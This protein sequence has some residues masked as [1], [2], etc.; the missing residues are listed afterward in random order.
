[1]VAVMSFVICCGVNRGVQMV[2]RYPARGVGYDLYASKAELSDDMGTTLGVRTDHLS[3]LLCPQQISETPK[4][5]VIT[6]EG[7]SF[8]VRF[9]HVQDRMVRHMA[10]VFAVNVTASPAGVASFTSFLDAYSHA[11]IREQN[12]TGYLRTAAHHFT[13]HRDLCEEPKGNWSSLL[14]SVECSLARELV[15]IT[16]AVQNGGPVRLY[17]NGWLHVEAECPV[18]LGSTT[19]LVGGGDAAPGETPCCAHVAAAAAA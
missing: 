4:P 13:K 12:R 3:F 16:D 8:H 11:L 1:M 19:R 14:Q 5:D 15:Q 7:F 6:V 17:V 2:F 10:I 18:D 9:F